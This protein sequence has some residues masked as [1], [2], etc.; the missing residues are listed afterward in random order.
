MSRYDP[1]TL[2]GEMNKKLISRIVLIAFIAEIFI[3]LFVGLFGKAG[4]DGFNQIVNIFLLAHSGAMLIDPDPAGFGSHALFF[5]TGFIQWV[6]V[7]ALLQYVY[8]A[9]RTIRGRH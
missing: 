4:A 9:I 1:E 3:W 6:I 2:S 8:L 7:V 5:I